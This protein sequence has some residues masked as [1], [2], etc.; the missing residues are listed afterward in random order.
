MMKRVSEEEFHRLHD[1]YLFKNNM[2]TRLSESP[3]GSGIYI[4]YDAITTELLGYMYL[5]RTPAVFYWC[6]EPTEF[7]YIDYNPEIDYF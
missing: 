2:G 7:K 3:P 6:K 1:E 5:N 4:Y